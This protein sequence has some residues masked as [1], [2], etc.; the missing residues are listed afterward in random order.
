METPLPSPYSYTPSLTIQLVVV[1]ACHFPSSRFDP[2][3]QR[4]KLSVR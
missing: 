1:V 2:D 4:F 3:L